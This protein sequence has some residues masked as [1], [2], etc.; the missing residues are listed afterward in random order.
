MNPPLEREIRVILVDDHPE[1]A[2]LVEEALRQSGFNLVAVLT[3]ASGLLFQ[4]EQH[5]PHL[6]M[7]ELESPDRDIL[8]SLALVNEHNPTAIVMFS[9]Q[10]DTDFIQQA[11][12]AGVTAYIIDGINPQKVKPIINVAMAQ[13]EAFQFLRQSLEDTRQELDERK[14]IDRA[15]TLVMAHHGVSE[16]DAYV[17]LRQLAMNSN[18]RI[19][20]V[21]ANV[22]AILAPKSAGDA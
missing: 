20:A 1:R 8:E 16:Q 4:I 11:V 21:A 9:Q 12:K 15:K 13:F 18:Q 10:D 6:I 22:I 14:I 17:S 2:A 5:R 7:V 19:A 3:T